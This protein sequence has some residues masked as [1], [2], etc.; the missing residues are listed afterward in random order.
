SV[1]PAYRNNGRVRY[2]LSDGALKMARK[3]KDGDDRPLW[4][5]VPAPGFTSTLNGYSYT[6]DN[7][8]AAP[9]PG[10][11]SILFGD[12]FS[13]YVVRQVH[14]VQMVRLDERFADLLQ[15]AFFAYARMDAIPDDLGAVRVL[16]F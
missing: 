5:P 10:A 14:G 13:A 12:V 8:M 4:V 11:R 7:S 6:V 9:A 2:V 1:D 15:T 16:E 3:L